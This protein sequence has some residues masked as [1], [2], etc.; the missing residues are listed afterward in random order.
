[1]VALAQPNFTSGEILTTRQVMALDA[2]IDDVRNRASA[3]TIPTEI[4]TVT[5]EAAA[6]N[7]I[8]AFDSLRVHHDIPNTT[9]YLY[10][11]IGYKAVSSDPN[12]ENRPITV[13]LY[14]GE[15]TDGSTNGTLVDTLTTASTTE[16]R[17]RKLLDITND[18]PDD[19]DT[20]RIQFAITRHDDGEDRND[21]YI[22]VYEVEEIA[23]PTTYKALDSAT[24][25]NNSQTTAVPTDLQEV[26]D[27]V[28]VL[29]DLARSDVP[30]F[31]VVQ[32]GDL[33][34]GG[35]ITPTI[36]AWASMGNPDPDIVWKWHTV[37]AGWFYYKIRLDYPY[38]KNQV[39]TSHLAIRLMVNSTYFIPLAPAGS[40]HVASDD[41]RS[42]DEPT[43][44]VNGPGTLV[45]RVYEGRVDLTGEA[46]WQAFNVQQ[47]I[48]LTPQIQVWYNT[49]ADKPSLGRDGVVMKSFVTIYYLR[50]DV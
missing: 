11:D 42:Y 33:T 16:V 34:L 14:Y 46:W 30:G 49:D 44:Y 4:H 25:L 47:R 23:I 45:G 43:D 9:Q 32:S 13:D 29:S 8:T 48:R 3:G 7:S 6:Y 1:M 50:E 12:P 41:I 2:I 20:V 15:Y 24:A 10:Y 36:T 35:V 37:K 22:T 31:R 40:D 17:L 27:N 38:P 18:A 26:S 39:G 5:T 28:I 21:A 19:G